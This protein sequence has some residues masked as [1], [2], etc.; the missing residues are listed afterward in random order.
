MKKITSALLMSITLALSH[1]A[2]ASNDTILTAA[3]NTDETAKHDNTKRVLW[4]PHLRIFNDTTHVLV[5]YTSS[6]KMSYY[7]GDVKD[8][9][10]GLLTWG[11]QNVIMLD[12]SNG[13]VFYD[14]RVVDETFL[15]ITA[16]EVSGKTVYN[17]TVEPMHDQPV[18][19]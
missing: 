11:A 13:E 15:H 2:I 3:D 5:V 1:M 19:Q 14:K 10:F 17:V 7:P 6:T 4:E 12:K 16:E 9:Y 18:A 8:P